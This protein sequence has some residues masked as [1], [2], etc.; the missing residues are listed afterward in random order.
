MY[1]IPTPTNGELFILARPRGNDWLDVD[2]ASWRQQH[3]DTVVSLLANGEIKDLELEQEEEK[4]LTNGIQFVSFEIED[5]GV[6]RSRENFQIATEELTEQL[7]S[8]KKIG[9]HCRQGIGRSGMLAIGIL[10]QLGES[11][12]NAIQTVSQSRGRTVP[13]TQEQ[14]RWLLQNDAESF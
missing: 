8:G 12:P 13:E 1:K 6:P 3:I 2:V 5:R 10:S 14:K 11:I 7:K 9:I 4:S